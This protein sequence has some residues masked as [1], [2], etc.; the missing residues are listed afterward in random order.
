MPIVA[1]GVTRF[2][3]SGTYAGQPVA[4]VLDFRYAAVTGAVPDRP[5]ANQAMAEQIEQ[6][7]KDSGM[8][9]RLSTQL[10][11]TETSWVDLDSLD[12]DVGSF[13][14]TSAGTGTNTNGM[15]GNVALRLNKTA[16]GQRGARPGKIYLP[17]VGENETSG[18]VNDLTGANITAWQGIADA[19]YTALTDTIAV[20]ADSF[21]G[22]LVIV[23]TRRPSPD[24]DP[25][26]VG[27]SIVQ[28]LQVQS[29]LSSQ[30]RRL[31]L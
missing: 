17:G 19:F 15:P 1:P 28:G 27:Y 20:E 23:R 9:A 30:R 2:T 16:S 7:Y 3:V 10:S 14:W 11:Y 6:A 18:N 4:N 21:A 25:I 31:T 13:T 5:V 12:G 8:F 24:A 22:V 26:Y 29:R